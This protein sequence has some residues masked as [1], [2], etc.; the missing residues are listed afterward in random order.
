MILHQNQ[1]M[2]GRGSTM[3]GLNVGKWQV[4]L[5]VPSSSSSSLSV[6]ASLLQNGFGQPHFH[7]DGEANKISVEVKNGHSVLFHDRTFDT[8][9]D[10]DHDHHHQMANCQLLHPFGLNPTPCCLLG[11]SVPQQQEEDEDGKT[12]PAIDQLPDAVLLRV[13]QWLSGEE[14]V[15]KVGLTCKHWHALSCE[16]SLWHSIHQ[17]LFGPSSIEPEKEE[18]EE[19]TT[20][21]N[22][23]RT[24]QQKRQ[25]VSRTR[26]SRKQQQCIKAFKDRHL[27]VKQFQLD[28]L[29]RKLFWACKH[30]LYL[31]VY[32]MLGVLDRYDGPMYRYGRPFY[33]L[34][35]AIHTRRKGH[36]KVKDFE[37]TPLTVAARRG[38]LRVVQELLASS[39]SYWNY[40]DIANNVMRGVDGS[41][42]WSALIHACF[43]GHKQIVQ[44]LLQAGANANAA[45]VKYTPLVAAAEN[46]HLEIVTMLLH[47]KACPNQPG[48]YHMPG[49]GQPYHKSNTDYPLN[50]A[51]KNGHLGIVQ[52]LLE[53]GADPN[54]GGGALFEAVQGGNVE[55]VKMLLEYGAGLCKTRI[56]FDISGQIN[57]TPLDL[58]R[59]LQSGVAIVSLLENYSRA[60]GPRS[61]QAST[62]SPLDSCSECHK[63]HRVTNCCPES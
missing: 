34:V 3:A 38:H 55:I 57:Q 2:L 22:N 7:D 10:H 8:L 60:E 1:M 6:Q 53:H 61:F 20:T 54:S 23:G 62:T 29:H 25:K 5:I 4:T 32:K 30:G 18:E 27:L 14:L 21:E 48:L 36:P 15:G 50:Q 12:K 13:F 41:I 51:A 24:D 46:G 17:S 47:A 31:E 43:K 28:Y 26:M 33:R 44:L 9:S 16:P 37:H 35:E 52:A 56:A 39:K 59:K 19:V 11:N 40:W 45:A 49:Y 42:T 63:S 58:A